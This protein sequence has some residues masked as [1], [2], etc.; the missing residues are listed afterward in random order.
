MKNT[1]FI[2]GIGAAL[3]LASCSKKEKTTETTVATTDSIVPAIQP[4][5]DSTAQPV[6]SAIGD[7]SENALDWD[8]TY[9]AVIPCADC[10]GIKTS[11]TLNK[12]KTFSISEEY[13]DRNSKNQDKGSFSWDA[14]GS[15]IT[16]KGKTA[17]YKYKVGENALYQLDMEGK[18][19]TGPNKDLYIFK[20]K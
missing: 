16:L 19:I 10:P 8:G 1:M 17:N 7:T 5:P 2:V 6:T 4:A 15:I 12:D 11:L 14:T 9:E 18:E 3:L 13:L 20:K